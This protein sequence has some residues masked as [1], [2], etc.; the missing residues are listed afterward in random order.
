MEHSIMSVFD[1]DSLNEFFCPF[2]GG[3]GPAL[4]SESRPAPR[5]RMGPIHLRPQWLRKGLL[6]QEAQD[7][8]VEVNLRQRYPCI[9]CCFGPFRDH[10]MKLT[11]TH[12]SSANVMR[13]SGVVVGPNPSVIQYT[14][15]TVRSVILFH[16]VCKMSM[17]NLMDAVKKDFFSA[18]TSL[19]IIRFQ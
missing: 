1:P 15:E 12:T 7:E 11:H 6:W 8:A 5:N 2:L 10:S 4:S 18:V 3:V 16:T 13:V 19:R 17:L 9:V 14:S